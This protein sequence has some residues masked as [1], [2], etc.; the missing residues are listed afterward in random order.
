MVQW[1]TTTAMVGCPT[2]LKRKDNFKP[3]PQLPTETNI[4]ADYVKSGYDR[5]HLSPAGNYI[6]NQVEMDESF[7]MSN[8][9]PQDPSFNRG[10]WKRLENYERELAVEKDTIYVITGGIL[11]GDLK[12]IGDNEVA[13]PEYFFKIFYNDSFIL[14][15]LIKNEKSSVSIISFLLSV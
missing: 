7:Y 6:E 5:G 11:K 2:P 15:F 13:V 3:D 4:G 9:S 1:E 14:C 12:T 8:I 10:I